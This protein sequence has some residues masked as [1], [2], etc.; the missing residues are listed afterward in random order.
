MFQVVIQRH[1]SRWTFLLISAFSYI[2][3][4]LSCCYDSFIYG[5]VDCRMS[6]MNHLESCHM[7][8]LL[9][10]QKHVCII[11]SGTKRQD[12]ILLWYFGFQGIRFTSCFVYFTYPCSNYSSMIKFSRL[13]LLV[14]LFASICL[15]SLFFFFSGFARGHFLRGSGCP[16]FA[17]LWLLIIFL[18]PSKWAVSWEISP[19]NQATKNCKI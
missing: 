7:R 3:Y 6:I 17:N 2:L 10:L 5:Y 15:P 13:A 16:I 19:S 8:V 9:N 1:R 12:F 4:L 11:F 18:C 14:S